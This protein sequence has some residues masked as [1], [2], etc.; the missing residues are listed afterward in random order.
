V[1]DSDDA[2]WAPPGEAVPPSRP[3]RSSPTNP[4]AAPHPFSPEAEAHAATELAAEERSARVASAATPAEPDA[5]EALTATVAVGPVAAGTVVRPGRARRGIAALVA[6]VLVSGGGYA[7]FSAATASGGA[8]TPEEALELMLEAISEDD[9][10]AAAAYVV[11]SE[12][13][14]L[15]Q[16]G[17]DVADELRRLEVL[18]DHLDLG[19]VDG[20]DLDFDGV[21]F[22]RETPRP[23]IAHLFVEQGMVT[24]TVAVADLPLGSV[25]RDRAPADFLSFTETGVTDIRP[26]TPIVAVQRDGRWY[27]SLWYTIAESS[28]LD[29]DLPLPDIGRRPASIGA[30]SP[31]DAVEGL[32]DELLRLD[33]RRMIG[34]LDPEE[35]SALYDYSP[36]FLDQ[37]TSSANDLLDS[38]GDDGW[39]WAIESL[40]LTSSVDGDHARVSIDGIDFAAVNEAGHSLDVEISGDRAR[41]ALVSADFWGEPFS[42]EWASSGDCFTVTAVE[43]DASSTEELCSQDLIGSVPAGI[44]SSL[45]DSSDLI[46]S[47]HR[48]DGRWFVSP[49]NTVADLMIDAL[50]ELDP[51]GLGEMIDSFAEL[52]EGGNDGWD[53]AITPALPGDEAVAPS[54]QDQLLGADNLDL[55][56]GVADPLF[57]VDDDVGAELEWW[58]PALRADVERGIYAS[59]ETDSGDAALV[60]YELAAPLEGSLVDLLGD[61][62]VADESSTLPADLVQATDRFGEVIWVAVRGQKLAFVGSY[63]ADVDD[64]RSILVGQFG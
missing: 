4:L 25:I 1:T 8:E 10:L 37:A 16:A 3:R 64:M 11:P 58:L 20:L 19:A 22:R 7:A 50:A 26:T 40:T 39:V 35:A 9:Y 63:G 62:A 57:L 53:V 28:R 60:V 38:L 34:M 15:V 36:L 23:G 47:L 33:V 43:G 54:R 42:V 51:D 41:L 44:R 5:G 48:I 45:A 52:F 14:T 55:L 13:D 31:E 30:E 49:T 59:V 6:V 21:E 2:V 46:L 61:G 12:R 17:L 29:R 32:L 56:V 18:A 24:A 27:L